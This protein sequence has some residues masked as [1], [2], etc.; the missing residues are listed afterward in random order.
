[1]RRFQPQAECD[2][3]LHFLRQRMIRDVALDGVSRPFPAL[4]PMPV[5]ALAPPAHGVARP[6]AK[7]PPGA[8]ESI[9]I[10]DNARVLES[11]AHPALR[12]AAPELARGLRDTVLA[13]G[14]DGLAARRWLPPRLEIRSDDPRAFEVVTG[15]S[16]FTGD[17][18]RGLVIESL[19]DG[20]APDAEAARH[21]GNL[22]EF[23]LGRRAHCLDVE[24]NIADCGLRRIEDGVV[25]FHESRLAVPGGPGLRGLLRRDRPRPVGTL[26]YE[27]A[28]RAGDPVLRLTVT[29]RAEPGIQL[30]AVRVT[31]AWDELSLSPMQRSVLGGRDGALS[32]HALP[33][34]AGASLRLHA[35]P[36]DHLAVAGRA[37]ASAHALHARPLVPGTVASVTAH[38]DGAGR[39]H[40]LLIRHGLAALAGGES[41]VVRED[42]LQLAG[43]GEDTA[44]AVLAMAPGGAAGRDPS[45]PE[46]PA[47]ALCAVATTLLLA[48][49]DTG[50]EE[51]ES[52]LSW[53]QAHLGPLLEQAPNLPTRSLC[54]LLLALDALLRLP[55]GQARRDL[56]REPVRALLS[57]QAEGEEGIF[58]EGPGQDGRA[59]EALSMASHAAGLLALARLALL[60]PSWPGLGDALAR[61]VAALRLGAMDL[62]GRAAPLE[63]ILIRRRCSDGPWQRSGVVSAEECGLLLRGLTALNLVAEEGRLELSEALR[64][65]A[66]VMIGQGQR[67]L[68]GLL[69]DH[70]PDGLEAR[71]SALGTSRARLGHGRAQAAVLQVLLPPEP[72]I[73]ARVPDWAP[74]GAPDWTATAESDPERA[75]D[76]AGAVPVAADYC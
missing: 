75:G 63:T 41:F 16:R 11:L 67:V 69:W 30:R 12:A 20:D 26:R 76:R 57:R 65:R 25:L 4:A 18:S 62:P 68:R 60:D 73:A 14:A 58:A 23:R 43:A 39:L 64:E 5:L 45:P 1:M 6:P 59:A 53:C 22:V 66:G 38:T 56:L 9:W 55:G 74:N 49:P 33:G 17:L 31:T 47:A 15:I 46:E 3:L 2:R 34:S 32:R 8:A 54:D 27:Y 21:T 28:I 50:A 44:R 72:E 70:G 10:V 52:L 19:H 36:M 37:D 71:A 35:G 7:A 42:R 24:D 40:W 61:G 48:P 13:L 51:R 29:L